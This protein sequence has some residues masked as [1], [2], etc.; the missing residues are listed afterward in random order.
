[1][2]SSIAAVSLIAGVCLVSAATSAASAAVPSLAADAP[3]VSGLRDLGPAREV[4]RVHLAI[5]LNYRHEAELV[6][7]VDA[8]GDPGSP[9]F[10]RFL[11]PAQFAGYFAPGVSEYNRV[12]ATLRRAGFTIARTYRNRTTI[13]VDVAA[14]IAARYFSTTI[15]RVEQPA[16]G[17]R[18]ENLTPAFT[19]PDLAAD[20]RGVAGLSNVVTMHTFNHRGPRHRAGKVVGP[21]FGPDAGYG[22]AAFVGAYAMPAASGYLGSGRTAGIVIDASFLPSDFESFMNYFK[23]PAFASIP[24]AVD[25]DGGPPAS[26]T[27]SVEATLDVEAIGGISPMTTIDVYELPSLADSNLIDAYSVA[28]QDDQVDTLNSSFGGCETKQSAFNKLAEAIALQGSALGIT[29]HAS[30][31]DSGYIAY[32]CVAASVNSPATLPHFVAVGGTQLNIN[33]RSGAVTSEVGWSDA[34][35]ASGGGISVEFALPNYQHHLRNALTGGRNVPDIAF[36]AS[37]GTGMSFYYQGGFNGP[38]GG[39]SLA[40]PIFGAA[41]AQINELDNSR[42]GF[43]N[44]AIYAS[45]A[46]YGYAVKRGWHFRDEIG[47]F[48][49]LYFATR[50]YDLMTGIGSPNVTALAKDLK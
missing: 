10:H 18:Y 22:P 32:G 31:G 36:D 35:G 20:V 33:P 15:H 21:L 17:L 49:G 48:N 30:S 43:V 47:G 41:L 46:K 45:F 50:G 6:S 38:I 23:I 29:F 8:Q 14:P 4:D 44:A 42:A 26:S 3:Q 39:T 40:S 9:Y 19:P 7:L 1:M 24:I 34:S 28:V 12:L 25:I 37:P 16:Y 5:G 2:K 11:S 27:D 13:D